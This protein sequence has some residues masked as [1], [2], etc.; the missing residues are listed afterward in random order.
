MLA[1]GTP[2]ASLQGAVSSIP[3]PGLPLSNSYTGN[4]LHWGSASE[5]QRTEW[6]QRVTD[7]KDRIDLCKEILKDNEK[8][9][10]R[11]QA[12]EPHNEELKAQY[13]ELSRRLNQ[14]EDQDKVCTAML[15]QMRPGA[16]APP[17]VVYMVAHPDL[18]G[19]PTAM[20][21]LSEQ[22]YDL[23]MDYLVS[24]P[25]SVADLE[26]SPKRAGSAG[27]EMAVALSE[28]AGKNGALSLTPKLSAASF[29]LARGFVESPIPGELN[30]L[31]LPGR[32]QLRMP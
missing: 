9:L 15:S 25:D 23:H 17:D 10:L 5:P 27:L 3:A 18:E 24:N 11:A 7:M 6:R 30:R 20:G 2:P 21:T 29:Y 1:G 28:R 32:A 22:E 8:T 12:K 14:L 13:R 16:S 4:A 19:I 31:V 26:G